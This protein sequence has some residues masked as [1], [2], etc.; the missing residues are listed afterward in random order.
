MYASTSRKCGELKSEF[1]KRV[2]YWAAIDKYEYAKK[3]DSS[4]KTKANKRIATYK[5]QMPAKTDVFSEGL[6]NSK[7]YEIDCWYKETVTIRVQ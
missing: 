5:K 3:I 2:G 6:I 1:L 7:T 4:V